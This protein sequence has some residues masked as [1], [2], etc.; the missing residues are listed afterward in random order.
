MSDDLDRASA[1]RDRLA[2]FYRVIGVLEGRGEAGATIEE[3]ARQAGV[4]RRTVYRDL[5]ALEGEI[6]IP[7]WSE[8]GRWGVEGRGFLPPL[9]FT[10]S[11]AMAVILAA[12]LVVRYADEYDPDLAGAFQK[13]AGAL[14]PVLSEHV[15]RSIEALARRPPDPDYSR[16]LHLLTQAWAE[17]RVVRF[18]YDASVHDP[19]RQ[20]REAIVR[21]YYLEPS[22]ATHAL[23]LIGW[24]ETRDATRTFKIE[25]IRDL[26]VTPRTFDPPEGTI[27]Q[28]MRSAWD[29][30]SDQPETEV[31]LRFDG[32]VAA[33]VGETTWHPSERSEVMDDGSLLWRARVAGTIEIRVW[34]L[35]WGH[36]VEVLEPAELRDEVAAIHRVAAARYEAAGADRTGAVAT[37]ARGVTIR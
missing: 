7:V 31:L 1:K 15:N 21:P 17:R 14:P 24:D 33:R 19:A 8:G 11:E 28:A 3:I 37:A 9:K 10:R 26:A 34:I 13:L 32:A 23:Y 36:Q 16:H 35:S 18:V 12:R 25:R 22:L 4:S 30:I 2:R 27:D 5:K 6:G 29:I 20:S